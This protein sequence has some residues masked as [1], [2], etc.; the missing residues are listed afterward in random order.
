MKYYEDVV[1]EPQ[2][3][4]A[5]TQGADRTV[6]LPKRST[7]K[8]AGYDFFAPCDIEIHASSFSKLIPCNVK[9]YMPD[10]EFLALYIRS[11]LATKKG[12]ILI[13]CVGVIDADYVDNPTNEGNIGVKF[14]NLSNKDVL[15]KKGDR[16]MQGIFQPYN[17][18][19][20]DN[21][22]GVRGGGYGSTGR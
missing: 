16:I 21:A 3:K 14:L 17:I 4:F 8:S 6:P 10:G 12:L 9:A 11:G 1:K 19:D 7:A 20:D 18:T 13:N 22:D 5:Y 2:R 15:I